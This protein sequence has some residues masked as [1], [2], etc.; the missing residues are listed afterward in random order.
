VAK[1]VSPGLQ[2]WHKKKIALK[3]RPN[4]CSFPGFMAPPSI[5]NSIRT[6]RQIESYSV[7]LSGRSFFRAKEALG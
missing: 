3:G 4:R 6:Q 2:G 5:L 7:A 1:Q